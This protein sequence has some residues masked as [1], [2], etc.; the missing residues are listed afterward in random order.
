M[1]RIIFGILRNKIS[2]GNVKRTPR[3]T[4]TSLYE[5]KSIVITL[6]EGKR[7]NCAIT[8]HK[9]KHDAPLRATPCHPQP[10]VARQPS[11]CQNINAVILRNKIIYSLHF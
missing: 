10:K 11:N 1:F 7:M 9:R 5:S 8:T 2:K 4:T 3:D 6:Y